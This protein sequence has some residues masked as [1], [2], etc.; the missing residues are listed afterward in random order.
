M[1]DKC[2]VCQKEIPDGIGRFHYPTGDH[3][4]DCGEQ[5]KWYAKFKDMKASEIMKY[6]G[7]Q[8]HD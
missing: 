2:I 5:S 7:I 8:N 3:C 4:V 1:T 6:L